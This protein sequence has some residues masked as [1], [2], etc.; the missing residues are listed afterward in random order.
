MG[1][2]ERI[3]R[4]LAPGDEGI[5]LRDLQPVVRAGGDLRATLE[6]T[7]GDHGTALD[8][9]LLRV[10]EERLIY[11]NPSHADFDFW[12]QAATATIPLKPRSLS[13]GERIRVPVVLRLPAD[14]E[15][16]DNHRRY[17]VTAKLQAPGRHPTASAVV[18]VV[19]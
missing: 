9:V 14:L 16:S 18:S 15:P 10:D 11:D 8:A 4:V 3:R 1:F 7:G 6:L 2:L 5:A 12:R 13:P 17:R 19:P